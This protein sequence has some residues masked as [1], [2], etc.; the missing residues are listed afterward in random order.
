MI[1]NGQAHRNHA[2]CALQVT[3]GLKDG[4]SPMRFRLFGLGGAGCNM[5]SAS[6]FPSVAIGTN[7][8]DLERCVTASRIVMTPEEIENFA[9]TDPSV[10]RPEI[11]P[12]DLRACFKD[13]DLSVLIAGLGGRTGSNGIRLFAAISRLMAKPSLSIVSLPFSV[14]S[15]IR[16]NKAS[17]T[18]NDLKRRTDLIIAF[19]NDCLRDLIPRMPMDKAFRVMNAIME[20]PIVDLYHVMTKSDVSMMKQ[21]AKESDVF[22]LGVGLGRGSFRD[23]SAIRETFESPWFDFDTDTVRSAYLVVSSFPIDQL[24]IDDVVKQVHSQ[25][26]KAKLMFGSYEDP[27]LGDRLRVML[28]LGRPLID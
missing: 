24:E 19:E 9:D 17:H 12:E 25:L 11:I 14:E 15:E 5:I 16:R 18:I 28:L 21:M 4:Q 1:I 10:L 22:K 3:F 2:M 13:T 8:R 26:P 27:T 6:G 20:R 23:V 7:A